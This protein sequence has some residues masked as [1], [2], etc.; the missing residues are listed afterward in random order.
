MIQIN[1]S[2][3]KDISDVYNA[4]REL[5]NN[6]DFELFINYLIVGNNKALLQDMCDSDVLDEVNFRRLLLDKIQLFNNK[7]KD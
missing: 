7:I 1:D 2:F 6:E 4:Y 5:S 3:D